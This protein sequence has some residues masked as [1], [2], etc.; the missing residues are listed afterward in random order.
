MGRKL[1]L[2]IMHRFAALPWVRKLGPLAPSP[3]ADR[4]RR[5]F[6]SVRWS[7]AG[8]KVHSWCWRAVGRHRL[9]LA[10]SRPLIRLVLEPLRRVTPAAAACACVSLLYGS[11]APAG[12]ARGA[13][14]WGIAAAGG[15]QA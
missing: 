7:R 2:E 15:G 5:G 6:P 11:G 14:R 1:L 3:C 9:T 13:L 4:G 8:R 10:R 12:G